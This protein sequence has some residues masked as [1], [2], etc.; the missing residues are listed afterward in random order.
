M[1]PRLLKFAMAALGAVIFA[2]IVYIQATTVKN[3]AY[4]IMAAA[5]GLYFCY[6]GYQ[7]LDEIERRSQRGVDPHSR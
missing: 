4:W 7:R 6:A 1:N 2:A 3:S 5:L